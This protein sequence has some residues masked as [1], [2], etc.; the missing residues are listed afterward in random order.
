MNRRFEFSEGSSN[1]FYEV[2]VAGSEVRVTFGRIGTS[3]QTQTKR[4]ADSAAARKHADKLIA[5][6]LGK[7]YVE[8]TAAA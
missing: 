7:G 8:L 4:F 2:T 1:K 5:Q 6:K 3:G